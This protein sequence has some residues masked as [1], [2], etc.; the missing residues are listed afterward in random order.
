MKSS[1]ALSFCLLFGLAQSHPSFGQQD[2]SSKAK[3]AVLAEL[4][5]KLD[6]KSAKAG[7]AITAKTIADIKM[8]DGSTLPKGSKLSG[9][10]T[11]V[12]SKAAG[13]GTAS[14][15][16]LFDRLMTKDGQSKPI[17]GVL[18]AIAPRPSVSDQIASSG[19]LPQASTRGVA[20]T[21]VA[22][23][24]GL[25]A[26]EERGENSSMPSGSSVKGVQLDTKLAADGSAVLHSQKD[27]HLES[28]MKI[29]V[30]LM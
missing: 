30:G 6:T 24:A 17:Q 5:S 27:I 15:S 9:K 25:N 29:E 21:A 28:G 11:Q 26:N 8:N 14:V 20:S 10:V 2:A 13:N 22:T 12:E 3:Q 18:V 19:S 16:V 7:D 1:I 4:T 23:G